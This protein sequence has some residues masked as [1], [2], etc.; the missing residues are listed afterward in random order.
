MS[1]SAD[2]EQQIRD[3]VEKQVVVGTEEEAFRQCVNYLWLGLGIDAIKANREP[4]KRED[5]ESLVRG[6]WKRHVNAN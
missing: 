6:L 3:V 4:M 2:I 1:S 5:I